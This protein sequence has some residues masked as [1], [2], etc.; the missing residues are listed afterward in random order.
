VKNIYKFQKKKTHL[1]YYLIRKENCFSEYLKCD[2]YTL[3]DAINLRDAL[4]GE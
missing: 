1:E 4:L 3:D 2:E